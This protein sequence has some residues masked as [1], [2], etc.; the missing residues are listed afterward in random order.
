SRTFFAVERTADGA[1]RVVHYDATHPPDFTAQD[2]DVV[3]SEADSAVKALAT[4]DPDRSQQWALDMVAFERSWATTAGR[5]APAAV[6]ASGVFAEHEV[7]KGS[8]LS[9]LDLVGSGDGRADPNG[10]GTHVAGIIAA[11]ANNGRGIA[12]AAPG[13]QILPIR[14]LDAN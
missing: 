7:L 8:V 6:L 5:C 3:T 2:A 13:V 4:S 11:H 14:V 12:G 9:G 1:L 10:H